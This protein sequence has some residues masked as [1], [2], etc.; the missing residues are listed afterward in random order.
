MV[1]TSCDSAHSWRLHSAA[2]LE[3]QV[4]STM[5][6]PSH[7]PDTETTSPWPHN[8]AE[9]LARKQQVSIFKSLA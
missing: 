2:T 1:P 3:D 9:R 5:T 6:T 8:N 4:T 7:Y